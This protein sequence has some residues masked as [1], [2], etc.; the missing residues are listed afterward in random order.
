MS[1]QKFET[2]SVI[3][4]AADIFW[5]NGFNGTSMQQ[6][7]TATGL[8]PGSIYLAFGNKEGLFNATVEN[9]AQAS[10]DMI[11]QTFAEHEQSNA[12]VVS[13]FEKVIQESQQTAYKCCYL[14]NSTL[15][16]SH[17]NP[18][19]HTK[20]AAHLQRIEALFTRLLEK[21]NAPAEAHGKAKAIMMALL[22]LR[23]YSYLSP[24]PA[25]LRQTLKQLLP[26]LVWPQH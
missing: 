6:L 9:Y 10:L 19:L 21:D 15:E 16:L 5:Q 26:W 4:A 14:L 2:E 12:A 3:K 17:Q 25:E 24:S 23:A 11:K 22:G 1:R 7:V 20:V 8:K 13:F 18:A